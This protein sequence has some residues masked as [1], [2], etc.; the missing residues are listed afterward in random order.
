MTSSRRPRRARPARAR[1][2]ASTSPSRTLRI[3][4]ST[5]PR[6]PATSRPRPSASSWRDPARGAG[7]E[8]AADRQLAEGEAV[9]GDEGVARVLAQRDG[10]QR[11]AVGG[12]RR[13]VLER[14]DG[15]V[16]LAGSRASRSALTKTPVPPMVASGAALRS[17]S[18]VIS[19]SST[20]WP[21]RSR[22]RSATRPDWVV[23]SAE[24]RV[25]R[26]SVGGG[27]S[28]LALRARVIGVDGLGVEAE[29]LGQRGG[30]GDGAGS[31]S[32]SSLTRT[33]GS[34][35]SLSATRRT[36]ASTSARVASSRRA[37]GRRAAPSRRRRRR[38]PSSAGR[39]R[40]G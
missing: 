14:V 18:V 33:V 3:R 22:I 2:T 10:G 8:A 36:A 27:A 24:A 12:R 20:S 4:V 28:L 29:Q 31:A 23:A 7:A 9:A 16:D 32:A 11:D 40:S 30:V 25:P 15:E 13:Q 26:R 39:R 1:T 34:W 35:S 19:T 38:W 6:M 5:L 21:R 37:A 17:P